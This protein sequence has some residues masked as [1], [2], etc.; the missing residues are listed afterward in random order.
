M[1]Q[2]SKGEI[3]RDLLQLEPGDMIAIT[4]ARGRADAEIKRITDEPV[5]YDK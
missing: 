2:N 1:V 3:V 5:S 4:C